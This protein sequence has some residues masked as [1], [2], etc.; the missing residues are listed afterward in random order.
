MINEKFEQF[1]GA[2]ELQS[3]EVVKSEPNHIFCR[4]K[5]NINV[6]YINYEL[7]KKSNGDI[8]IG[9]NPLGDAIDE[10]F[11]EVNDFDFEEFDL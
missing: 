11:D 5:A 10:A 1:G 8:Y 9:V 7:I 3:P 6:K 2:L 4:A